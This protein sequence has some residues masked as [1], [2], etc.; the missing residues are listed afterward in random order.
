MAGEAPRKASPRRERKAAATEGKPKTTAG[1]PAASKTKAAT[2]APKKALKVTK[3]PSTSKKGVVSLSPPNLGALDISDE[4]PSEASSS[5]APLTKPT[6]LQRAATVPAKLGTTT[7]PIDVDNEMK[8]AEAELAAGNTEAALA[9]MARIE[10]LG[11]APPPAA[12]PT[13]ASTKAPPTPLKKAATMAALAPTPLKPGQLPRDGTLV[14]LI[15]TEGLKALG[16]E[17]FRGRMGRVVEMVQRQFLED[18]HTEVVTVLLDSR[19]GDYDRGNGVWVQVPL[20][21]IQLQ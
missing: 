14:K 15:G 4:Q 12:A 3:A 11:L 7:K 16:L 8:I 19:V 17:K 9:R 18:G 6:T 13:A 2:N 5:A 21:N 1:V 10:E 20:T